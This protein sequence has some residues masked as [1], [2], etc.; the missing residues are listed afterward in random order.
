MPV[1][2]AVVGA[3]GALGREVVEALRKS[4]VPTRAVVR[5]PS[6]L[7]PGTVDEVRAADAMKPDS[8]RGAFD[9]VSCVFSSAGAP[10]TSAVLP[11][12]GYLRIDREANRNLVAAAKA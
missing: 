1:V 8:L 4:G 11:W 7:R 9:G 5:D 6:R 10:V 3:T 12:S 2:C